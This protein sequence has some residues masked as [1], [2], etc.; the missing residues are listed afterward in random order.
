MT[1]RFRQY[2]GGGERMDDER[3]GDD[4]MVDERIG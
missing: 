3:M 4:R 1:G 2:D